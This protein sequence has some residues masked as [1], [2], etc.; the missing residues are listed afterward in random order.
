ML[1]IMR[2]GL[3]TLG[4]LVVAAQCAWGDLYALQIGDG[5]AALSTAASSLKI[6]K[7]SDA[8]V[9]M[10]SL[11]LPTVASPGV[12]PIV[13]RGNSS[14]E[15]YMHLSTNGRYLVLGGYNTAV[16]TATPDSTGSWPRTVA[17]VDTTNFTAAGTDTT[18]QLTD[19]FINSSFRGV[20]SVDGSAFWMGGNGASGSGGVRYATLGA[21]ASTGIAA[22][23][24]NGRVPVIGPDLS[25]QP[26]LYL[27]SMSG[28]NIGVSIVG[29]GL[30]TTSGQTAT[31]LP[32][33]SDAS[34]ATMDYWF[35]DATTLY[36]ADDRFFSNS[37]PS[38]LGGIQKWTYD[39]GT[40]LWSLAY[41]LNPDPASGT[42]AASAGRGLT[43]TVVGGNAVLYVTN[44][45]GGL[46]TIT[47]TGASSV[48]TSLVTAPT[49]TALRGIVFVPGGPVGVS[50]DYNN[51][52]VVDGADYVLWRDGGTLQNDPNPGNPTAQ[53]NFWRSRFGATSGSGSGLDG[54]A[55]PEPSTAL[56]LLVGLATLRSRRAHR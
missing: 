48:A 49:N 37:G 10:S 55:V 3:V 12:N 44:A 5:A 46:V 42:A 24:N 52:G 9:F 4:L 26:Q 56:L 45:A 1:R 23:P 38:P 8:G 6:N 32:G 39:S 29:T 22:T 7:Y 43:G 41:N 17:R 51:N 27:G 2:T 20:A 40:S 28:A 33:W 31:L 53:Y 19:A 16:G 47:D 21:T 34:G 18:T 13:V 35:K 30:P 15:S 14:T 25:N 36:K 50:G 11:D 54:S